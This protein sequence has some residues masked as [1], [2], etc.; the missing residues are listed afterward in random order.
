MKLSTITKICFSLLIGFFHVASLVIYLFEPISF[1]LWGKKMAFYLENHPLFAIFLILISLFLFYFPV[2]IF[3]NNLK[4]LIY[5]ISL[6]AIWTAIPGILGV[7]ILVGL[8]L[9]DFGYQIPKMIPF[10]GHFF[11]L[12][13][14]LPIYT[15]ICIPFET[16]MFW[17]SILDNTKI[18]KSTAFMI[19]MSSTILP[20]LG[21]TITKYIFYLLT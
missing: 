16:I 8:T 4:I 14:I 15:M 5:E 18:K 9:K 10:G 1:W 19:A 21:I 13:I 11:A 20:F 2:V 6:N 7:Y 17:G 12:A 3:L